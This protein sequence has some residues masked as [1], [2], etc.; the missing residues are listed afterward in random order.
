MRYVRTVGR[1]P[2]RGV[3][4]ITFD[5]HLAEGSHVWL[6]RDGILVGMVPLHRFREFVKDGEGSE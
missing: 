1:R 2:Y 4:S 5:K 6:R 3:I